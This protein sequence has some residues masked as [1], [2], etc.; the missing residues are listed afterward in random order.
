MLLQLYWNVTFSIMYKVFKKILLIS[1]SPLSKIKYYVIRTE[2]QVK[3]PVYVP[4][5]LWALNQPVLSESTI[6]SLIEYLDSVVC[7][8]LPYN[9]QDLKLF[10]LVNPI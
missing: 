1:S 6:N 8:N 4:S 2:F 10:N 3:G 9:E 5:L 7:A